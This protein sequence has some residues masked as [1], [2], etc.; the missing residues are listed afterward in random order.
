MPA[1]LA[2][3][4]D[5]R[6]GLDEVFSRLPSSVVAGEA[7][8]V[9]VSRR[10]IDLLLVVILAAF[11]QASVSGIHDR[12]VG[13]WPRSGRA[14]VRQ[15]TAD[16]QARGGGHVR[17]VLLLALLAW[18]V[19]AL[20]AAALDLPGA[21]VLG[22]WLA[23]WATV[24]WV[25]GWIGA[26]PVVA[27]AVVAD[28]WR[29]VL[30]AAVA[31]AFAAAVGVLRR[32]VIERPT[33]VLGAGPTVLAMAAG[34]A[35]GG[36]GGLV[37]CLTLAA[38]VGAWATTPHRVA[39]PSRTA[40][41]PAEDA[42]RAPIAPGG[43]AAVLVPTGTGLRIAPGGRG[44]LTVLGTVAGAVVVWSALS[45]IGAVAVWLVVAVLL[46]IA[47][48]RP[49]AWVQ[50]RLRMPRAVA[51]GMVCLTGLVVVAVATML[52]V[53]GGADTGAELS[54][55]LPT[56]VEDLTSLPVLGPW[57][58]ERDA[59]VWLADQMENLPQRLS[60]ERDLADV[61]PTVGARLLDAFWTLVLAAALLVDGP[62]LVAAAE[63]RV[64]A[65][66]RRQTTRLRRSSYLAIGGYLAGAALVA[67]V[68]GLVVFGIA[69]AVGIALAPVL[70]LWAFAWNF[71]PQIGGFM[72]GLP[73]I[74][75][76]LAEGPLRAVVA[77]L[78]FVSYQ[79][80][81]NHL[82]Q[83]TV[84]S[85]SIDV[86]PWVALLAA[87]AGGAAAG[88]VGAVA[89]TPLIG[90]TLVVVRELRSADFPGA[91]VRAGGSPGADEVEERPA[92]VDGHRLAGA[93]VS[94]GERVVG[95]VP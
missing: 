26:A 30:A 25:G 32:R 2:D 62:R 53:A 4:L 89:L 60:T 20:A 38:L 56:V 29:G 27:L 72:G 52:T 69:V 91:T 94:E 88:I 34:L 65:R 90:V 28:P 41:D 66:W 86:P 6:A 85:E 1:R 70:A 76:A 82:I 87:L 48:H 45:V 68:N 19:A 8:T 47:L 3:A 21:V 79:F 50:R 46:A 11:F 24:P 35:I 33:F 12:I 84:I 40:V 81:E 67:F 71:V 63:E 77:G 83:P 80:V 22:A 57:L 39:R 37:V 36:F 13:R 58:E 23:L 74:V 44:V 10:L 17:R 95:R 14:E 42:D 75:L 31:T 5:A 49:V 64:P 55:E 43:L 61:L 93:G 73:L 78:V 54:E 18:P 15:L 7:D 59:A 16:L 51:I 92:L 9:G